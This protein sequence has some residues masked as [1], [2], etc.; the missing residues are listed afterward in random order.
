MALVN[1]PEITTSLLCC[2]R[3]WPLTIGLANTFPAWDSCVALVHHVVHGQSE[4]PNVNRVLLVKWSTSAQV[5][6]TA[7]FY[8][9]CRPYN[10]RGAK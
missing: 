8:A 1:V 2:I 9:S 7:H 5:E 3:G 10:G 6:Q 4:C